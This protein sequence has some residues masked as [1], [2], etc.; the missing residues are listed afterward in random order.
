MARD[1]AIDMGFIESE[2]GGVVEAGVF[3]FVAFV[4][5]FGCAFVV[6]RSGFLGLERAM[7]RDSRGR[8]CLAR[9]LAC[10]AR[11][12]GRGA[13]RFAGFACLRSR[14]GLS[15]VAVLHEKWRC[16]VS[17]LWQENC[18]VARWAIVSRCR[19]AGDAKR[20]RHNARRACLFFCRFGAHFRGFAASRF[21]VAL[22]WRF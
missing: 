1:D 19:E 12:N 22:W 9:R 16:V 14:C 5:A 13:R 11:W 8:L 4:A 15:N 18:L 21:S 7:A 2:G 17:S 6:G 20:S 10:G 3:A